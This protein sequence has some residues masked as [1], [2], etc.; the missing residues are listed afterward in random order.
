M[1]EGQGVTHK[2]NAV[3]MIVLLDELVDVPVFHPFGDHREPT[4]TYRHSKQREDIWMSE[5]FPSDSLSAESL[6][7]IHSYRSDDAG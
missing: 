5:V 4:F 2:L 1:C 7:P 6:Q 3:H